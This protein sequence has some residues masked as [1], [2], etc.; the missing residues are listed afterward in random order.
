MSAELI[1]I[2][3][4]V[5]GFIGL[6]SILAYFFTSNLLRKKTFEQSIA[7][8]ITDYR[9]VSP[10]KVIEILNAFPTEE[11]RFKTFKQIAKLQEEEA[12]RAYSKIKAN[13][14]YSK[15]ERSR[16]GFAKSTSVVAALFFVIV[17][18]IGLVYVLIAK[19][20]DP[21]CSGPDCSAAFRVE[22]QDRSIDL[23]GWSLVPAS[24]EDKPTARVDWIDRFRATKNV[25]GV[26]DF[27]VIRASKSK[28]K[29]EFEST[30]HRIK[31]IR[32]TVETPSQTAG[33]SLRRFRI[34]LDTSQHKKGDTFEVI[35]RS[36]YW[37]E[38]QTR[39]DTWIGTA[40]IYPTQAIRV[41]VIAPVAR[42]FKTYERTEY[43]RDNPGGRQ[44]LNDSNSEISPDRRRVIWHIRSLKNDTI[45]R[46]AWTW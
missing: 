42:P 1:A 7:S 25:D 36:K 21:P 9:T 33:L 15:L 22:L 8:A 6:L 29:P 4:G 43:R 28:V 10:E 41:E 11:L 3:A 19:N 2:L 16:L 40:V 44:L 5:S 32:E 17:A 45:Y 30:S 27:V 24:Q 12:K 13:I 37:N 35:L 23:S 39:D 18:I 26:A 34:V 46:L 38:F 20:N 31:E 14:D